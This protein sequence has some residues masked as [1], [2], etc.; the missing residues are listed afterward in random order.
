MFGQ[1]V[2]FFGKLLVETFLIQMRGCFPILVAIFFCPLLSYVSPET[3][4]VE[5]IF[6]SESEAFIAKILAKD[7]WQFF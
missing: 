3:S 4:F 1:Q 2:F 5:V 7:I 6:R